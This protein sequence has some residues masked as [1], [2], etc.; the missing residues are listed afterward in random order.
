MVILRMMLLKGKTQKYVDEKEKIGTTLQRGDEGDMEKDTEGNE[1]R[2]TPYPVRNLVV[3]QVEL[4]PS[5]VRSTP[6]VH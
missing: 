3:D 1:G 4:I 6:T 2:G 5:G